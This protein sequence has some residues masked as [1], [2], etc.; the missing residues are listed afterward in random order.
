M[1]PGPTSLEA[2]GTLHSSEPHTCT[3]SFFWFRV[4]KKMFRTLI[5]KKKLFQ[6][7]NLQSEYVK[8]TTTTTMILNVWRNEDSEKNPSPKWDLNS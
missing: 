8:E 6:P 7:T 4:L 2:G 1:P 5:C 3:I